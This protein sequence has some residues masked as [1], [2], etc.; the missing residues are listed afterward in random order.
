VSAA[1]RVVAALLLSA[2]VACG[3]RTDG[4]RDVAKDSAAPGAPADSST[5]RTG[6][7]MASGSDSAA[8]STADSGTKAGKDSAVGGGAPGAAGQR[9]TAARGAAGGARPTAEEEATGRVVVSGSEGASF[10][11]L[12]L[13]GRGPLRLRGEL[14][15]ELRRLSGAIVRV[16]GRSAGGPTGGPAAAFGTEFDVRSYEVVSVDGERPHVGRVVVRDGEGWLAAADT[17]RLVGA[18]AEL[19]SRPGSKVWV[20]GPRTG[21]G[22]EVR[23]YG[24]IAAP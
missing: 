1:G 22:I 19:T 6:G 21:G 12:Q 13:E 14:E 23:S 10:V 16:V 18:P 9:D 11:T 2:A 5:A 4:P 3:R 24:V 8:N 20:V 17:V 15:P 7:P